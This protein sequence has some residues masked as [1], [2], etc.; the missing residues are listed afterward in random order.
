[1]PVERV[2][3]L[4]Q[5]EKRRFYRQPVVAANYDQQRFGGPSGAWVNARELALVRSLLPPSGRVLDLAAGTGRLSADLCERGYW[6]VALDASAAM[7]ARARQ[8]S[9]APVI[10]GDAFHLPFD[11]AAFDAVV[12]LRLIFHLPDPAPV[13]AEM[14]RVL[15]PG[16][17]AIFDTYRWSPR[18]W[19]ALAPQR[20]G[21]RVYAHPSAT[22]RAAAARVGWVEGAA[23]ACFLFSPYVYRLLPLWLV[24]GLAWL[25]ARI[26][27]QLRARVFWQFRTPVPAGMVG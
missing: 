3:A 16:G 13:F 24:R 5:E 26:P 4:P 2:T 14:A 19:A 9:A 1:M 7:L 11:N 6:P 20:W 21:A 27:P 8:A 17:V 15:R 10:Q 18:A 23:V 25:E 22:V 12:A